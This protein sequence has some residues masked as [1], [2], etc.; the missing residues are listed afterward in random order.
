[1]KV[2]R[3]G[4]AQRLIYMYTELP[5][6]TNESVG[7]ATFIHLHDRCTAILH[8]GLPPNRNVF[9]TA[10]PV[11][12]DVHPPSRASLTPAPGKGPDG[13]GRYSI[14]DVV[15]AQKLRVARL[16]GIL[17]PKQKWCDALGLSPHREDLPS[18]DT[19]TSPAASAAVDVS[20][21][22]TA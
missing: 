17:D 7:D 1:M 10:R 22:L 2:A 20:V 16:Y 8:E 6:A 12:I 14:G 5:V 15:D 9:N 3:S 21:T 19:T 4:N 18:H 13:V 11:K